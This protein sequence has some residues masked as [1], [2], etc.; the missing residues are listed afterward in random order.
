MTAIVVGLGSAGDVHPNVGLAMAL[1]RRGHRVVLVAASVFRSL[2][3]RA[4]LEF[5][6]LGSDDQYYEALHDPDMWH[7][8][9]AFSVVARRLILPSMRPIYEVI[10]RYNEPGET[11]VASPGTAFGARIAQEKLGVPLASVHLQ[12]LTLRS[13]FEPGCYGFPDIIGHL[14]RPLRG[15][16]LWAVDRLIVD[17]LLANETNALRAELGL[18]PAG[19]LFDRWFHSPQLIIG[20]FPEWFAPAQPDWPP[21]VHLTGFPLWDGAD[22]RQRSPELEDFLEGGDAPVVFTAGSAMVQG[23]EFFRVSAEVCRASGRRGLFLTQYSEQLPDPLPD[24]VRHFE[25]VPFSAVLPR[26]SAFVHHGG[27][28][29]TAQALAAGVPQLVVPLAHDQPDNAVRVRRLGVGE[30]LLPKDYRTGAVV[31]R[32]NRLLQSPAVRENC[33]RRAGDVGGSRSLEHACDL[34]EQATGLRPAA[35]SSLRPAR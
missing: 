6:G 14:P 5:A 31:E 4:G 20:L 13:A 16:Y 7:P 27:I 19:R 17:R 21:N 22:L 11:V 12:P 9:R 24:G 8:F 30:F 35:G 33:T 34:I 28:G 25:Y 10:A 23:K 2:A 3:R 32:L 29:T 18:S 26:A 15:P 1:R